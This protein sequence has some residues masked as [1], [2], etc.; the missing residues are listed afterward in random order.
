MLSVLL[1]VVRCASSFNKYSR[2]NQFDK[3]DGMLRY[4]NEELNLKSLV[5]ND[6][7]FASNPE[8]FKSISK[9]TKP[10]FENILVYGRKTGTEQDFYIIKM[11]YVKVRH[12]YQIIKHQADD[13]TFFLLISKNTAEED[14]KRI[15]DG[16]GKLIK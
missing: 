10:L 13:Q 6:Y 14:I 8:E 3:E 11:L 2:Y 7:K 9:D 1:L 5:F 12:D 16:F 4:Y 15:K